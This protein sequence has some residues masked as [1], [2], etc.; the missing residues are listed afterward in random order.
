MSGPGTTSVEFEVDVT[1]VPRVRGCN[2]DGTALSPQ[3]A[4]RVTAQGLSRAYVEVQLPVINGVTYH[5]GRIW[6]VLEGGAWQLDGN[7]PRLSSPWG[8]TLDEPTASAERTF[9]KVAELVLSELAELDGL[10]AALQA[11]AVEQAQYAQAAALRDLAELE[12]MAAHARAQA[13]LAED[14]LAA[15]H[16]PLTREQHRFLVA[17]LEAGH[18]YGDAVEAAKVIA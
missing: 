14:T 11:A 17:F 12:K 6:A 1:G 15:L 3:V 5:Y 8:R 2:A 18:S 9:A 16:E 13:Q 10:A 7:R 4:V